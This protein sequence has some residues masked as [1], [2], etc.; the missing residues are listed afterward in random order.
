MLLPIGYFY[1]YEKNLSKNN[2]DY[3]N[4]DAG[5]PMPFFGSTARHYYEDFAC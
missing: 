2:I 1:N 3:F 5:D 4:C